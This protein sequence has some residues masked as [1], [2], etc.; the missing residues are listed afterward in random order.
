[1]KRVLAAL[2]PFAYPTLERVLG[3]RADVL[4]VHSLY[5]AKA[6]LQAEPDISLIVC[7]VHFD[8]SRMFDLLR[9][10]HELYPHIPFVCCR[11]LEM[12]LPRISIE[13]VAVSVLQLGAAAFF[14]FPARAREVGRDAADEEFR[15]LLLGQLPT[16]RLRAG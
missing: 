2:P 4:P 14:D 6:L 8:E 12:R 5:G 7:G 10:A 16:G 15:S 3:G 1:M 13:A 11:I 9:H